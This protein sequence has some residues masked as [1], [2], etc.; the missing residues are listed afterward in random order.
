MCRWGGTLRA[1]RAET[2]LTVDRT[3]ACNTE[4]VAKP[5]RV[6]PAQNG[7]PM[8]NFVELIMF[9]II[10]EQK[11]ARISCPECIGDSD[12]YIKM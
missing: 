9:C 7:E 5:D 3:I 8:Q 4:T 10:I 1:L 12:K 11:S 2:W 6:G